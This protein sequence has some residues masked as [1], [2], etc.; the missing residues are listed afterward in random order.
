ME[1]R[2]QTGSERW[3]EMKTLDA[4]S[5]LLVVIGALNWGLVGFLQFNLVDAVF[6]PASLLSRI[7]YGLVGVAAVYWVVEWNAMRRRWVREEPGGSARPA[8]QV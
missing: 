6:G 4:I 7:V 8:A 5:A 1:L 2:A 3:S